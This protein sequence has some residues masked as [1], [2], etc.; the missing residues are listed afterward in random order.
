MNKD[1]IWID[2]SYDH[3][4][5]NGNKFYILCAIKIKATPSQIVSDYNKT[6]VLKCEHHNHILE[7]HKKTKAKIKEINKSKKKAKDKL[8]ITELHEN[9]LFLNKKTRRIK[10]IFLKSLFQS[11]PNVGMEIY[12]VYRNF[13][14]NNIK[15]NKELY[16]EMAK[17]LLNL[18]SKSERTTI[19][20][21][22][23][24]DN[25]SSAK[26]HEDII[27]FLKKEC[28]ISEH[29]VVKFDDSQANC[30]LQAV[31]NVVGTIR[32]FLHQNIDN[33]ENYAIIKDHIVNFS[34]INIENVK[35]VST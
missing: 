26:Q 19:I 20:L 13:N 12:Y 15:N 29:D 22:I 7:A 30:G 4:C 2:E 27:N 14:N 34:E 1:F 35:A 9:E 32:R 3:E 28:N 10:T 11:N 31:D 23:C 25:F 17:E 6:G 24:L 5:I 16:Q 18:C 21:D 33:K 8:R